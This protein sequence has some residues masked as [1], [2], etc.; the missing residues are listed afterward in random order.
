MKRFLTFIL[1]MSMC[2]FCVACGNDSPT[3]GDKPTSDTNKPAEEQKV[4]DAVPTD[5]EPD[6][7]QYY[8]T[9][10]TADPTTLDVSLRSDT[11][12]ST[13]MNNTMVG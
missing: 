9:Y 1:A 6:A 2:V 8:N 12:S 10:I 7:E 13:I 4:A 3:E 11:Y 5:G